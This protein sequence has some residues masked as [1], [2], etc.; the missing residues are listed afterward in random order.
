[1]HIFLTSLFHTLL[2]QLASLF[3]VFFLFGFVLSVVNHAVNNLYRRSVG[4]KG[5]LWTAWIGTPIHELG[6]I[7]FAKLFLHK[8]TDI[9]FFSPN[10]RTGGLG[11]VEHAYHRLNIFHRIGNFFIGIAPLLFGA[12][13]VF[14]LLRYLVP[15]GAGIFSYIHTASVYNPTHFIQLIALALTEL[16]TTENIRSWQFWLFLYISFCIAAHMAPSKEDRKNMWDGV[17]VIVVLLVVINAIAFFLHADISKY[18]L[19]IGQLTSVFISL[20]LYALILSIL[21]YILVG[22]LLFPWRHRF[23]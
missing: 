4:W 5:I 2:V 22:V 7:V 12:L 11:H 19:A 20:F 18:V 23:E 10:P 16:F 8:I 17:F 6:H 3:G 15:N 9:S 13:A 1:M 14:L 21:H